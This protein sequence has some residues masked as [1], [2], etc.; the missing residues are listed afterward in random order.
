LH[1]EVAKTLG[2][3]SICKFIFSKTTF[4]ESGNAKKEKKIVFF[5][6]TIDENCSFCYNE[7]IKIFS[8]KEKVEHYG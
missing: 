2:F 3:A 1:F 7:Y 8:E 4:L 5:E 6:K